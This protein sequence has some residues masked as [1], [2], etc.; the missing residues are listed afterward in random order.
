MGLTTPGI[1]DRPM[2]LWVARLPVLALA[3]FAL[4]L[5]LAVR[6]KGRLARIVSGAPR[7]S[8][9]LP[10]VAL[11][12]VTAGLVADPTIAS[13]SAPVPGEE[14]IRLV[15]LGIRCDRAAR[16]RRRP[17]EPLAFGS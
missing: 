14:S 1:F 2:N 11:G 3:G 6:T 13:G 4:C 17:L 5:T 16:D 10:T 9:I 8:L 15:L 12:L 7:V